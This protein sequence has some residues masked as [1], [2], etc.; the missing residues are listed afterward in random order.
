MGLM[1]T[2]AGLLIGALAYVSFLVVPLVTRP[3]F[4][5]WAGGARARLAGILIC[6]ATAVALLYLGNPDGLPDLRARFWEAVALAGFSAAFW[7]PWFL[8]S[9]SRKVGR[10]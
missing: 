10:V 4:V 6:A 5:E 7:L 1:M 3:D 2:L 9:F 8:Y